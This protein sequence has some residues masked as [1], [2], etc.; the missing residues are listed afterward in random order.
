MLQGKALVLAVMMLTAAPIAATDQGQN[1]I[2]DVTDNVSERFVSTDPEREETLPVKDVLDEED[3]ST[4]EEVE[5]CYTIEEY[6]ALVGERLDLAKDEAP[7]E[8]IDEERKEK[9]S[10]SKKEDRARSTDDKKDV[11]VDE[12]ECLTVDQ[13]EAKFESEKEPCFTW[14]DLEKKMK[15]DRKDWDK[16][17]KDWDKEDNEEREEV[18]EEDRARGEDESE[19]KSE[20]SEKDEAFMAE[21]E[22]LKK[23]CEEGDEDAC[24]ELREII[25]EMMKERQGDW[26]REGKDWGLG[27]IDEEACL[28]MKEWEEKFGKGKKGKHYK[29]EYSGWSHQNLRQLHVVLE[30][31]CEEGSEEACERFSVLEANKE[32]FGKEKDSERD[33]EGEEIC[34]REDENGVIHYDCEKDGEMDEIRAMMV[35]LDAACEDGDEASC[36]ELEEMMA[37][38]EEE[39]EEQKEECGRE[40]EESEDESEDEENSDEE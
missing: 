11:L 7:K 6:K 40:K 3:R 38:L 30:K 14:K 19:E 15:D 28:T 29:W 13:W 33:W 25:A 24:I 10:D 35:E 4:S 18:N 31:D 1:F 27:H 26:N 37:S 20:D 36:E 2:V 16:E 23:A 22:E 39:K 9:E 12:E 32:R 5:T 34:I 17:G 21:M 8:K